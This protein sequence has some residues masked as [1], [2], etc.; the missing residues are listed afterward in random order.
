MPGG[1]SSDSASG[2]EVESLER[3]DPEFMERYLNFAYD[4]VIRQGAAEGE[5]LD[6]RTRFMAILATLLGC[7]GVDE[8]RDLLPAALNMGVTPVEAKEIVYQAVD[9]LGM[10]RV[11]P[12]LDV[13]NAVLAERGVKLPLPSQASTESTEESRLAGGTERQVEI[14]GERMRDFPNAGPADRRH[15]NRWL[16][17]N[18]FGDYY[19]RGGLDNAQREMITF[20]YLAA[21]GGV[22]PQLIA[23]AGGNL[24]IGNDKAF[25]IKVVS[26]CLPYIGYPRSLNALRCIDEAAKT[27]A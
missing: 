4:D 8:F 27:Q 10:G 23:H 2:S 1:G 14:F 15:I 26:A 22:E 11:R 13:T 5:P 12:F 19:T 17:A 7:Q 24:R 6:D 25:L 21:Q 3:T 20:C 18:C 16:A 9:Y